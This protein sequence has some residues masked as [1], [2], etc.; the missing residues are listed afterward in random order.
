MAV[1]RLF[2]LALLALAGS[3][4]AAPGVR[5]NP[6]EP[7]PTE[8]P[9]PGTWMAGGGAVALTILLFLRNARAWDRKQAERAGKD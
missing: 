8:V 6:K 2:L 4:V 3:A 9:E 7:P 5:P 1:V